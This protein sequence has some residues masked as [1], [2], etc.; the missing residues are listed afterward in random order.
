MGYGD[1]GL[2]RALTWGTR[3]IKGKIVVPSAQVSL[4]FWESTIWNL[5]QLDVNPESPKYDDVLALQKI[6][7]KAELYNGTLD[8]L[9]TSIEWELID[10]QLK[11]G[12]IQ[13][14]ND[15]SAGWYGPKTI[16]A[17]REEY[18]NNTSM[19][20]E[21]PKEDFQTF[22]HKQ[23]SDIYRIILEYGD[24]QVNP[25]SSEQ[26]VMQLQELLSQLWEY[27]G[28][29]NGHYSSVEWS[30]IALQKK[31][32]LIEDS[33]DWGAGYFGNKTKSALWVYYEE[34]NDSTLQASAVI[35]EE[36]NTYGL[37]S[38][39][40]ETL[41]SAIVKLKARYSPELVKALS[42]QIDTIIDTPAYKAHKNKLLY[43]RDML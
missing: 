38:S 30:L 2:T 3:T 26:I 25:D 18:G 4:S 14:K 32:G 19:L 31:I 40:R 43:I 11:S 10:F 37:S 8:G 20:I 16:A 42:L 6:F 24:L 27:S 39:Q 12:I 28:R 21:E 33:E 9:Y 22:N 36:A 15:E 41:L 34:E 29:I 23:A 1:E 7:T 35:E 5:T 17:L 13:S